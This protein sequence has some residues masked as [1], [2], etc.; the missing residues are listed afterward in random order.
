MV[1]IMKL[2]LIQMDI[3]IGEPE[4]NRKHVESLLKQAVEQTMKPDVVVLPELWNTG[5]ALE[6]ANELADHNGEPTHAIMSSFARKHQIY[7]IAGS[8]T[9]KTTMGVQNT[10][11][12]YDRT[13]TCIS[14]YSKLHLFRL[15]DEEKYLH[16]GTAV[17]RTAIDGVAA[18][19]MICY[20]IR[21]PE[22]ARKLSLE[23]AKIIFVPAQWPQ[24]RLHHWRTLLQARAIE[25]QLFVVACN[26]VGTSRG[27]QFFGHSMIISPWGEILAEAGENEM[28]LTADIDLT[29][30]EQ[31][32]NKIPVFQDRRPEHYF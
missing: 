25:N 6:Q 9:N 4:V 1:I 16:Q 19:L 27:T 23:G 2:S 13:G 29:E 17:G 5:Y 8:V 28:L 12:V 11:F 18:G 15:M 7:I 3:C 10:T 20:D 21:F 32:R 31:V 14:N 30:T 22:L 24:P 26:R